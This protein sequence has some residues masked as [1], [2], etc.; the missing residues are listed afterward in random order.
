[1]T[2]VVAFKG[3]V[4]KHTANQDVFITYF[5]TMLHLLILRDIGDIY[6]SKI[7]KQLLYVLMIWDLDFWRIGFTWSLA[8][9]LGELQPGKVNI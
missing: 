2:L 9:L 4:N 8:S 1:V 3:K 5:V 6:P 7:L